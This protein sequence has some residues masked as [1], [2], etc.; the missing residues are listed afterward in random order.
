MTMDWI[1][2]L[3]FYLSV[4]QGALAFNIDPVA[5]KY[6]SEPAAA[7]FG[8]K[9]EQRNPTSLLISAPMV[10]YEQNRRGQVYRCLVRDSSCTPLSIQVPSHGINM[11]LGLSMTKDPDSLK[12]MVCGPTI[13]RECKT[14]TTYNGMCFEIDQNLNVRQPVPSSLEECPGQTD[15]AFLLDGSGS[16]GRSDFEKMKTFVKDLIKEFLERDTKFAVAQ[17]SGYCTIHFDLN[18]FNVMYWDNQVSSIKQ[19]GGGTYTAAA[20]QKVV[21]DVFSTSRGSRPKAKKI[22]IVIT[23]GQS[24]DSGMLGDAASKADAKNIIR[25]AIGVGQ[26]FSLPYAKRELETIASS[27]SKNY[28][29]Q[30]DNFQALGQI[31]DTLQNSIFPIEGSQTTGESIKM[32]MAQEGFSAAYMPEGGF[33]MGAVGAFQWRGA[34][35]EYTGSTLNPTPQQSQNMEPDSYMGYSMAV[36]RTHTRQFTILGAP[37]FKHTGRVVFLSSRDTDKPIEFSGQ[38]GA[39]FGAEVCAM[40]V[41]K[42]SYSDLVLISAPMFTDGDREGRVYVCTINDR[43]GVA[44]QLVAEMTLVGD[45]G[46]MGRFGTSLAPLPDLNMDGFNDLAVGAPLENDGQGSVY[47]F[48]G[49]SSGISKIKSQ[50]ISASDVQSGLKYFG[51]SISQTSLDM[52]LDSLPDLAVGSKGAVLLLRSRPIVTLMA[53][54]SFNPDKIPTNQSD[55]STP[56]R[57]IAEVCFTMTRQTTDTKDLQAKINYTLTL[58]VTR[59]A[60]NYRAYISPKIRKETKTIT[61]RLQKRCFSHNFFTEACPEDS[62]NELSN[63]LDFTFEGLPT[64]PGG[65]SSSLSPQSPTT[66][67]HPLGF[68]IN[69]GADNNCIDNLKVD[70]NFTRSS[71]VRVGIDEVINVTVSVES[72]EENSYNSHIILTYPAGLSFRK[73]TILQ[74]RVECNSSDS[75]GNVMGGQSDCTIDK[76]IFKSNSKALLVISYGI[77]SK[78]QFGQMMVFT[79][80][81]SSGNTHSRESELFKVK[82]IGVKYSIFVVI[83]R[84]EDSTSYVNFTAGKNDLQKHV[85]QSFEVEN[86]GRGFNVTVIIKVPMKLGDK[87]IWADPNGIQIQ[88]CQRHKDEEPTATEFVD[89]LQKNHA[90]DCSVANCGVFICK[91]VIR[92]QDRNS[93]NIT[94]NL[95][96]GWIEQIG[97]E[98]AQFNLVSSATV[99]YD[100]NQYIYYSSDSKNNPPIQKIETQVEV[101]PE[102]DFTKGVI[103][104]VVGGLLLLALIT[105]GLYKAGFF[106]SQ[107]KQMMQNTSEDGPGNDGEAASPE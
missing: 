36:A 33:Q 35:Q 88:G 49:T 47:I 13:P 80:N 21:Q 71:E 16:V 2:P 7:G 39:Y 38:I 30:V 107:L 69:C 79:A 19:Q 17:Y 76:P 86:Y 81:A 73:F 102:V 62:L 54:V 43:F 99:D 48:H 28:V 4:P 6:V 12:I 94:G 75:V 40:D 34:Y 92:N 32:E 23:D 18:T 3:S 78:T 72:R 70:F 14:I 11:S 50:R 51:Q 98:S 77:D 101:Y 82:E 105:A 91:S 41:N 22:L 9:V 104:G 24:N 42:D 1:I 27:P 89:K 44:C 97:L 57:N 106:K 10:Q 26:A 25:F 52:S 63:E 103:G 85:K 55:C 84:N 45:A 59:Q 74:G 46:Q 65:L 83:K 20:I 100:R 37:R 68:E 96:S 67:Y 31:K 58:D 5:W 66:T 56:L 60:P 90:V 64:S 29:F 15:I 93:Y 8:Y 87:D 95:S 61:L 53:R